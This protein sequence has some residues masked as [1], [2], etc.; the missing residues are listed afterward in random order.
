MSRAALEFGQNV[1]NKTLT[2]SL[3]K[4]RKM[5][6]WMQQLMVEHAIDAW[7]APVA[8][9]LAPKGIGSTGDFR[10]NAIWSSAGLPIITFPTGTD[11]RNLPYSVQIVG[12]F[13]RDESLLNISRYLHQVIGVGK[14]PLAWS[15]SVPGPVS[16]THLTLPTKA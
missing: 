14:L 8:P 2:E 7:I 16:Y 5:Q 4:A 12:R 11:N 13:G 9:D 15:V 1:S 3:D 10:M 6:S